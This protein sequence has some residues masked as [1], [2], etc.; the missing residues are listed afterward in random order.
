MRALAVAVIASAL[1]AAPA[2]GPSL[3][4]NSDL[5]YALDVPPGWVSMPQEVLATRGQ[6]GGA[7]ANAPLP[8]A[9]FQLPAD[10]WFHVPALVITHF[11]EKERRPNDLYEELARGRS[12]STHPIAF[13]AS[14]GM[15]LLPEEMPSRDGGQIRRVAVFKPGKLGILHLDFYLPMSDM[16]V[17]AD[18]IVLK[19]LDSVHFAPGYEMRDLAPRVP[20]LQRNREDGGAQEPASRGA[21]PSGPAAHRR[22]HLQH[23]AQAER[24]IF[25]PD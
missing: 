7:P 18:P 20:I 13:D 15:V 21:G 25:I 1:A 14:R 5:H 12:L 10:S 24:G 8:V 9:A 19:V 23:M 11:P 17:T 16:P 3:Y 22:E 4:T 2:S 6:A